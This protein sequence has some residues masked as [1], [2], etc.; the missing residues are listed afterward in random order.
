[1][2]TDAAALFSAGVS[3]LV[4]GTATGWLWPKPSSR[5]G[6]PSPIT[7][8]RSCAIDALTGIGVTPSMN[9]M[10]LDS[11]SCWD[12]NGTPRAPMLNASIDITRADT[13]TFTPPPTRRSAARRGLNGTTLRIRRP[14]MVPRPF[15]T[16]IST[17]AVATI[18]V[19]RQPLSSTSPLTMGTDTKAATAPA[20]NPAMPP[21]VT[22][23]PLRRPWIR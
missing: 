12:T 11:A 23:K 5:V 13:T 4:S 2:S 18:A 20:A 3:V 8:E 15:P 1:M 22:R 9:L 6:M 14:I 10:T 7:A 21:S 16:I 17:T 19:R